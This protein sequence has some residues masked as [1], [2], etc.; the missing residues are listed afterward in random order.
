FACGVR[1]A[2]ACGPEV[3]PICIGGIQA[4]AGGG[5]PDLRRVWHH[6]WGRLRRAGRL[7]P[8]LRFALVV[9]LT[10]MA[11][12]ASLSPLAAAA[13]HESIIDWEARQVADQVTGRSEEHTSELQ[14]R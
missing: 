5:R 7:G 10:V 14:S 1:S 2:T 9:G 11:L 3:A 13:I 12:I 4:M 8:R 6:S